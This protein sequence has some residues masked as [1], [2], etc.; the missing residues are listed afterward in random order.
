MDLL[1]DKKLPE[2]D[3]IPYFLIDAHKSLERVYEEIRDIIDSYIIEHNLQPK[4]IK[5]EK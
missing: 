3:N 1:K 4:I 2:L 5:E